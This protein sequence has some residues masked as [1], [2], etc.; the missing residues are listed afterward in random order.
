MTTLVLIPGLI[1]DAVVWQPVADAAAGSFAVYQADVSEG[2]SI[3]GMAETILAETDGPLIAV[4]HSMGG[5]IAMEMARIA[6][7]RVRGGGAG[8]YRPS[9]EA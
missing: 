2:T 8:E 5:R 3:T 1:S 7:E 4:G 9:P 6:P